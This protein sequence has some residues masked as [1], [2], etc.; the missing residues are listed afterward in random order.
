[1]LANIQS[2]TKTLIKN[3]NDMVGLAESSEVG[4]NGLQEESL[5]WRAGKA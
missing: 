2:V 4:R 5:G 1:M 3:V